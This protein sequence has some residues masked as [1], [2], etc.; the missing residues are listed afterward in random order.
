MLE[1]MV[2]VGLALGFS[3]TFAATGFESRYANPERIAALLEVPAAGSFEAVANGT[4]GKQDSG[5]AS[6]DMHRDHKR[7]SFGSVAGT[8]LAG[9]PGNGV[10]AADP[11]TA[12]PEPSTYALLLGGLALVGFMA[13]RRAP[14]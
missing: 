13:R 4:A 2:A 10:L 1:S 12:V 6:I 9:V 5:A 11:V 8:T 7:N 3:S 14:R